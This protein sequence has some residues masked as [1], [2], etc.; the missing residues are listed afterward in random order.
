MSHHQSYCRTLIE[1]CAKPEGEDCWREFVSRFKK[2][3]ERGILRALR[4]SAQNLRC[5]D[6]EDLMQ[7]VM[8][9]LLDH[10]RRRLRWCRGR[11]EDQI[12][13]YLCRVAETVTIDH[14]RRQAALKRRFWSTPDGAAR[15]H[16][17]GDSLVQ[18]EDPS[19]GPEEQSMYREKRR[20]LSILCKEVSSPKSAGRDLEIFRLAIV[21]GWS[22][23]EIAERLGDGLSASGVDSVVCRLRRRL[24]REGLRIPRRGRPP[25]AVAGGEKPREGGL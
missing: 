24:R 10:D 17:H 19:P 16:P 4:S 6:R 14:L 9:R 1:R 15:F 5:Y 21:E 23:R 7:D 2:P 20:V 22:S 13:S 25:R 8:C 11:T 12:A 3:I 18:L